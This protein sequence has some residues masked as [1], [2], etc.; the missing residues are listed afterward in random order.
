V[1]KRKE[2]IQRY[3]QVAKNAKSACAFVL[4]R[5]RQYLNQAAN[6]HVALYRKME[7]IE[8]ERHYAPTVMCYLKSSCLI[9]LGDI[10]ECKSR[11]CSD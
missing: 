8:A 3:L 2:L 11:R 7:L 9:S 6:Y 10:G 1:D 5:T 4:N